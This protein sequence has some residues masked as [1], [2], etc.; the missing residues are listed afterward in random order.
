[1]NAPNNK[2]YRCLELDFRLK[3]PITKI[4]EKFLLKE[5]EFV[6]LQQVLTQEGGLLIP[7]DYNNPNAILKIENFKLFKEI[8]FIKKLII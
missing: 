4:K 3:S 2:R 6:T 1:M 7:F 8:L 5:F